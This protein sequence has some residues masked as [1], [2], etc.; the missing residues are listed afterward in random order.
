M[1]TI[2]DA[3]SSNSMIIKDA[4]AYYLARIIKILKEFIK[5]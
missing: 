1:V 2:Y 5:F 4:C 3:S